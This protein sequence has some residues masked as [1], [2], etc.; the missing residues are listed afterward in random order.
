MI[1][2]LKLS[3]AFMKKQ[4]L[5]QDNVIIDEENILPSKGVFYVRTSEPH[6]NPMYNTFTK[7]KEKAELEA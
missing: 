5:G 3:S 4:S 1:G 7:I 2:S 6:G